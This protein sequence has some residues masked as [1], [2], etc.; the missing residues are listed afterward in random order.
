MDVQER[1][2]NVTELIIKVKSHCMCF[3]LI[4]NATD[5]TVIYPYG[6]YPNGIKCTTDEGKASALKKLLVEMERHWQASFVK[7][8]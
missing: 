5:Y 2:K 6:Y 7:G 1:I 8:C 4:E 3:D